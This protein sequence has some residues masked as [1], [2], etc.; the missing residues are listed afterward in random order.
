MAEAVA[1]EQQEDKIGYMLEESRGT[2]TWDLDLTQVTLANFNYKKMSL[3]RDYAQLIEQSKANPAFDRVFSIE[4]RETDVSV[5]APLAPPEQ[6]GV[7]SA[8]ATQ[9]AAVGLA[10]TQRSFI[11]QGRQAPASRRPSPT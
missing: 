6:W 7:V 3:V 1:A 8:D 11:I 10:R 2:A 5:P 4:P 9:N